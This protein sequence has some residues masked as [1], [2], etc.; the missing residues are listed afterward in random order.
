VRAPDGRASADAGP[1]QM[2]IMSEESRLGREQIE[3]AYAL[4]HLITA[5]VRVFYVL[6]D[7]ERPQT[8][9]LW[10]RSGDLPSQQSRDATRCSDY[11]RFLSRNAIVRCHAVS[12]ALALYS[13]N[14]RMFLPIRV[15][16][17]KAWFAA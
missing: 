2:L 8:R 1:F 11:L 5:G 17:A 9:P 6:E 16:F 4:K 13:A 7:R 14:G 10:P 15:S 3:T 12:A